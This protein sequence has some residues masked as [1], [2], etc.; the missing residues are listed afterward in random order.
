MKP[1]KTA[2]F[3]IIILIIQTLVFSRLAIF[4]AHIDLLLI[5]TVLAGIFFGPAEGLFIGLISGFFIDILTFPFYVQIF[6]RGLI[7]YLSGILQQHIFKDDNAV[8]F[9]II[10]SSGIITYAFDAV[11]LN[12][13]FNIT[14]VNILKPLLISSLLN[15]L[16]TLLMWNLVRSLEIKT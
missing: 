14:I 11:I 3:F 5:F 1:L 10:F 9:L 13:F 4:N 2:A 12:Q 8:L 16:P 15:M 6:S 7:G